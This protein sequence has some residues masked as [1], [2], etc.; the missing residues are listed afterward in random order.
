MRHT[1]HSPDINGDMRSRKRHILHVDMDAF[2]ASVEQADRPELIGKPVIVGGGNRGV[3]SAASYEARAYGIHSAMP[4]FKAGQLCPAGIF[5]PVRMQRYKQISRQIMEI[6]A[7][8]SPLVE[9]A[10]VDE[11]YLDISGTSDLFGKP[12]T[13]AEKIKNDIMRETRLTCSIGIA[14]NKFLA[15]IASDLQKPD[16]LTVIEEKDVAKFMRCLP[17]EKI[18]GVGAKT[19]K[20]LQE[21]GVRTASDLLKF[22]EK[23]WIDRLGKAGMELVERARGIDHSR[24]VPRSEPKSFS[25]ERTFPADTGD[26][27][28]LKRYLLAQAE[29][30]G[31]D[32]RRHG[33]LGRTITLKIKGSDFKI[34]T[35]SRTLQDPACSTG[36]I[37]ETAANLLDNMKI[38]YSVR[39]IGVSVSNLVKGVRQ[40]SLI[41]N[42]TVQKQEKLDKAMDYIRNRFGKEVIKRGRLMKI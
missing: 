3:V 32:L 11:A 40:L 33:Y 15:K 21:L 10:S 16:G 8:Y 2:F 31:M 23:F 14:P 20:K 4:I 22:P 13:V 30:V 25:A 6:L 27:T 29:R 41:G 17:V 7:R 18:P 1:S 28:E 19:L 38:P 37:F 5:L 39:L 35:R 26:R 9:Q 12:P 34:V 24:V 42:E 36:I